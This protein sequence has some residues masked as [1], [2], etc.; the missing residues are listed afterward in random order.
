MATVMMRAPGFHPLEIAG[1]EQGTEL[2]SDGGCMA[3]YCA[4]LMGHLLVQI[5][6]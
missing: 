3:R 5:G 4:A 2:N 6:R 1:S